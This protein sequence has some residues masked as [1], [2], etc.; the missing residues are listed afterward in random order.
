M[1]QSGASVTYNLSHWPADSR[2]ALRCLL[3]DASIDVDG[4]AASFSVPDARRADVDALVDY[5][6]GSTAHRAR[7]AAASHGRAACRRAGSCRCTGPT[8]RPTPV[9]TPAGWYPDPA[10]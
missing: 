1:T 9:T 2:D 6:H 5:L 4:T 8:P 7:T 3:D 10:A